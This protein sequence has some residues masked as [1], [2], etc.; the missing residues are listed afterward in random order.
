[1]WNIRDFAQRICPKTQDSVPLIVAFLL[2]VPQKLVSF[3]V[4]AS[5]L[6]SLKCYAQRFSVGRSIALI[7]ITKVSHPNK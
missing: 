5:E 6:P 2:P 3:A 7:L 1:M 4:R